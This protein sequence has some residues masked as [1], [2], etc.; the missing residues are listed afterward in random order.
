M[1]NI[2]YQKGNA[3]QSNT[4]IPSH[5][6]QNDHQQEHKQQQQMLVR[7]WGKKNP[8]MLLER[9]EDSATTMEISMEFHQKT[10]TRPS[11]LPCYITLGHIAERV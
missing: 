2:L 9:M 11:L 6:S 1:F 3:N 5:S 8:H 4:E 10:K 7:M